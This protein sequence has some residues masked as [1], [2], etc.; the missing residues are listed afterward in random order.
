MSSP[1]YRSPT[2]AEGTADE[3]GK[4]QAKQTADTAAEGGKHVAGVAKD[5]GRQVASE[6]RHQARN[7]MGEARDQIEDQ[8][9]TQRDRLVSN[10][11]TFTN[12]LEDMAGHGS[13]GM[14]TDLVRQVAD[15]ARN[16]TD[17][18]DGREPADLLDEVRRFARRRP[19]TFLLGAFAAGI[20]T[21]RV[22]RGAKDADSGEPAPAAR[23]STDMAA[24]GD[25]P[26]EPRYAPS[27]QRAGTTAPAA[28]PGGVSPESGSYAGTPP[29]WADTP[30]RGAHR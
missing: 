14:A 28:R 24:P 13:G 18:L 12:E 5:E 6:A 11:R 30:P 29:N 3:G 27:D 26:R 19:G 4:Q 10:L 23:T 8:S 1:N 17:R 7:L 2:S 20:V 15:N 22:A 21:G 9:R 25:T 16:L